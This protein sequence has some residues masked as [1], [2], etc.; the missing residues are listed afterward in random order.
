MS[1]GAAPA[2]GRGARQGMA[3]RAKREILVAVQRVGEGAAAPRPPRRRAAS[4]T[5][6]G[7]PSG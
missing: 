2:A 6:N 5:P 4:V 1:L 7:S 3:Q